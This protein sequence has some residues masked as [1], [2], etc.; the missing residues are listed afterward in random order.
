M[1][2]SISAGVGFIALFG[3]AVLNGIVLIAEFNRLEKEGVAD[4]Y[5][6]VTKGL[7]TRL[8]PVIMTAAVA[9][10]GFLPMALS[11][12]AGAEV[13]KPLATVVIGGLITATLLTLLVL[14][15][16]YI[17]FSTVSF[18]KFFKRKSGITTLIVILLFCFSTIQAQETKRINLKQA[19]QMALDSNLSVRSSG[20]SVDVQKALKGASWDIPKTSIEGQY[21]QINSYSKDNS[22][23][24]L[25]SFAFPTVYVNQYK[26][27]SANVKSSEW[28]LK[29][30][31]LEKAT[32]VKQIYWQLAYLYSKQKLFVYQDSL[33]SGFQ[34]AAELRAKTGETNRLEMISARTESLEIKNKLQQI[35]TDLIIYNQ[36]LQTVL[37]PKR[38]F[39]LQTRFCSG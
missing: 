30:S 1:N 29:T 7:K 6:R 8:R 27:A 34:K 14:P 21:G 24:V 20:Y 3:I 4:I 11:S 15:V 12:S 28:Q 22:F 38:L 36:K 25:Q 39:Y 17:F 9:S 35:S 33:Y 16:F 32:Q 26:L 10:L 19:I 23:S 5:E 2:F 18:R 37:I 31:Q 13:Q